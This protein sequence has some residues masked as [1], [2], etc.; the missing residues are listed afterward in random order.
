MELDLTSEI[1]NRLSLKPANVKS[2][3]DLL[4]R[5]FAIA[6]IAHFGKGES[7]GL[8]ERQVRQIA[9]LRRRLMA[10]QQYK[11]AARDTLQKSDK[12]TPEVRQALELARQHT[13]VADL[14]LRAHQD[15][16]TAAFVAKERGLSGLA[17]YLLAGADDGA[18]LDEYAANFTDHTR[19]VHTTEDALVG[20]GHI[21]A[22]R[23]SENARLRQTV[24]DMVW[25][26]G[27]LRCEKGVAGR[28][29][30]R[31][32]SD[33]VGFRERLNRVPPHRTLAINRG[34]RKGVLKVTIGIDEEKL[35][36]RALAIVVP[37]GTR[38]KERLSL[39]CRDAVLR[40]VLPEI[41]RQVRAELTHI[42]ET[43]AIEV[44]A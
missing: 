22:E 12:L 11:N 29:H 32:F 35:L 40:L 44:F 31:E 38:F 17:D 43:H 7:G 39:A 1:A 37:D 13:V 28:R 34:E 30:D 9:R 3:C 42:A 16:R 20:A 15:S 14:V 41:D 10:F 24:R 33:F 23:F 26:E 2:V 6:Y 21:I 27:E 5:G 8:R 4:G 18:G 25:A 19:E 36:Q